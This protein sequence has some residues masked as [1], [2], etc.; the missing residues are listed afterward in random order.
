MSGNNEL[1]F[2]QIV[3]GSGLAGLSTALHL[4]EL[5]FKVAII[6]KGALEDCNTKYAQG[7]IACV[8]DHKD[9]FEGHIADTLAA[10]DHLCKPEVV[11]AI[12]EAGPE[13][14]QWLVEKGVHFTT[15]GEIGDNGT[16]KDDFH[17]GREGGHHERRVIHAGDITGEEI[18]LTLADVVRANPNITVFER[19]MA[20]DLITSWRLGW[21]GDNCCIGAYVLDIERNQIVT[22]VACATM[23]ATGGVGKAYLYTSNPDG[24]CG[25]GVALCHRANVAIANMEFLQFHPTILYS[26]KIKSFLLSEALRGEGAVLKRRDDSGALVEFMQDCHPMGSLAPR[27]IVARAIDNELKR[28][29]QPCV[30]LDMRGKDEEFLRRRFPNIFEKCLEAGFNLARDPIPAVPAAHFSCGGVK[31]DVNGFTG[32]NGLYAAGEVASTGLHGANRLAS[33][34]LLE[35]LVIPAA[36]AK[37]IKANFDAL[38]GMR[39]DRMPP[40]WSSGDATNS[41]EMVVIAHNWD[42]IRRFMWDYVGIVRTDKRLER[43]KARIM[44]I[45]HEIEK[46]YWDF[47]ITRD[48]IELR[49]MASVAEIIID[50]AMKRK[51]SRGLHFNADYPERDSKMDGVDTIIQKPYSA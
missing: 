40:M 1:S 25:D 8:L 22:F 28:S 29:G 15:R 27:D 47:L 33:N 20:I 42:E 10:G 21:M 19:H 35:A 17:L 26:P 24:A 30:Y 31:T 43:A 51:E 18:E 46:Y 3:I 44:N 37:H 6:T 5:G 48:L 7:G 14:V 4:A 36:A 45:R 13:H 49:N 9:T 12:V 2:D 23:V 41:D 38:K 16:H 34:S 11:K 50:S 39:P 32:I